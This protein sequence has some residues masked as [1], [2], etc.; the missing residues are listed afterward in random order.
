[1]KSSKSTSRKVQQPVEV[2]DEQIDRF[3]TLSHDLRN[4]FGAIRFA[5]YFLEMKELPQVEWDQYLMVL[6]RNLVKAKELLRL[7]LS[8]FP[9]EAVAETTP[10]KTTEVTGL[11]RHLYA[12]LPM[13]VPPVS[14][15]QLEQTKEI[16]E[17]CLKQG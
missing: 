2:L 7:L 17:T 8:A 12:Q 13:S 4:S 15:D 3:N 10:L 6:D 11:L 1:M 5:S 14:Q 16:I 9:L